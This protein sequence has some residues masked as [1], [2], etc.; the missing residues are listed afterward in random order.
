MKLSFCWLWKVS[1]SLNAF[2]FL[3]ITFFEAV[4]VFFVAS[5]L[6]ILLKTFVW[7][8]ERDLMNVLPDHIYTRLHFC[9]K[10]VKCYYTV[11]MVS[12]V[13][14]RC[15]FLIQCKHQWDQIHYIIIPLFLIIIR[16]FK[17]DAKASH[18]KIETLESWND[19]L[20]CTQCSSTQVTF[21]L[22]VVWNDLYL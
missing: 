13:V 3:N 16:D 10:N 12:A 9:E 20:Y 18:R 1:V 7:E 21:W 11:A 4:W 8:L 14:T 2:F 5:W 6:D 15:F 17:C 19:T 22:Y